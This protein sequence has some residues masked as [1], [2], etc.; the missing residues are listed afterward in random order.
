M[1]T[2]EDFDLTPL[3]EIKQFDLPNGMPCFIGDIDNVC[4][5]IEAH[6]YT[7]YYVMGVEQYSVVENKTTKTA[8]RPT[9]FKVVSTIVSRSVTVADPSELGLDT[10][11]SQAW[12]SLPLMPCSL[13]QMMED[14]FR[15]VEDLYNTESIVLLTYDPRFTESETPGDG[16]GILVPDQ[17]NTAGDCRYDHESIVAEKDEDVYIVG[18]AHSHP[19]MAAFASGTDHKDQA[20]FPGIHITYGWQK[21]V[22]N[23]ATQYYIE[24]QTPGGA[25]TMNPEQV[26]ES[27]PKSDPAPEIEQ[28]VKKVTKK[29]ATPATSSSGYAYS[30]YGYNNYS[31]GK[32]YSST[33][34]SFKGKKISVPEHFPDPHKNTI[35]GEVKESENN[36]PF[37]DTRLIKSDID[38][39]RCLSCHSYL[40]FEKEGDTIEDILNIRNQQG[41]FSSEIDIEKNPSKNVYLWTRSGTQKIE[42]IHGTEEA[43][44]SGKA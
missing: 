17:E 19:N 40:V 12:Y 11:T 8:T 13:V 43:S 44:S 5:H 26:F 39:R 32:N 34:P 20:D 38:K 10:M 7:F 14:F 4:K 31:T 21:S 15:Q 1:T 18:S 2:T 23:N 33:S 35:V 29:T 30:N 42:L 22:N 25:F 41:I 37:C 36:C 9:I 6:G 24:L 27:A 28:W 16:W 3:E